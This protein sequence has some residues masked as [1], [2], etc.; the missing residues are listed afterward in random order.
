MAVKG[1]QGLP[2]K[3]AIRDYF[4]IFLRSAITKC[5]QKT[6][7]I[8]R[9]VT[10]IFEDRGRIAR[11]AAGSSEI[12]WNGI[13]TFFISRLFM[14]RFANGFQE[15]DGDTLLS[16][17]RLSDKAKIYFIFPLCWESLPFPMFLLA[18]LS[19]LNVKV[20]GGWSPNYTYYHCSFASIFR[21]IRAC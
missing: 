17:V 4:V 9:I 15:N 6:M 19:V 10:C 5:N 13:A 16:T 18:Y 3:M 12:K 8:D 20:H 7:A 14:V 21:L 1:L 11:I 2:K